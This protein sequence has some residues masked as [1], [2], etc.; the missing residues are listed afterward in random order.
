MFTSQIPINMFY[1]PLIC[2]VAIFLRF[3]KFSESEMKFL[4]GIRFLWA[5]SSNSVVLVSQNEGS[6]NFA[7]L[8]DSVQTLVFIY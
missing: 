3:D 1:I 8:Y 5:V 2:L 6:F 4:F 7:S